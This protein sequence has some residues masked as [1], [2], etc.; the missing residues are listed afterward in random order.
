MSSRGRGKPFL[1]VAGMRWTADHGFRCEVARGDRG[2]VI[3]DD[4]HHSAAQHP[5]DGDDVP[6]TC[7]CEAEIVK[8]PLALVRAGLTYSCGSDRCDELEG[9][10]CASS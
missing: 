9:R 2:P 7:W 4:A 10:A 6:V 1:A 8:V 3:Y 5:R